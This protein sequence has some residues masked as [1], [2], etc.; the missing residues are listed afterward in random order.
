M[1][2]KMCFCTVLDKR[3]RGQVFQKA[4]LSF[5]KKDSCLAQCLEACLDKRA[6]PLFTNFST[7]QEKCLG[8]DWF[9]WTVL[10]TP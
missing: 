10:V 6:C 7:K 9:G 8:K 1:L 3:S 5:D 4:H 2:D